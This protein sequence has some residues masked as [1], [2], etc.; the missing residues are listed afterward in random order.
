MEW[1]ALAQSDATRAAAE[2]ATTAAQNLMGSATSKT[3]GT[4][5]PTPPATNNTSASAA[6]L[7]TGPHGS[8]SVAS[9]HTPG[10]LKECSVSLVTKIAMNAD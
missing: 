2:A 10:P 5:L 7:R 6:S 1:M 9:P 8:T 4:S 3:Q